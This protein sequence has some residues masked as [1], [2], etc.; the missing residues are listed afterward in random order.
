VR[1]DR[2]VA[3]KGQA[4]ERDGLSVA[5]DRR[6]ECASE[7]WVAPVRPK[8]KLQLRKIVARPRQIT[9][10]VTPTAEMPQAPSRF[11]LMRSVRFPRATRRRVVTGKWRGSARGA[12]SFD[13]SHPVEERTIAAERAWP[14][15]VVVCKR[16]QFLASCTVP[17]GKSERCA[18]SRRC[19][20]KVT[21]GRYFFQTRRRSKSPATVRFEGIRT[22]QL[23]F[24]RDSNSLRSTTAG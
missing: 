24:A 13:D 11:A 23:L 17:A 7:S 2:F 14:P 1:R 8:L 19:R 21:F 6:N 20:R 9:A 15:A 10:K 12:I 5:G 18:I 16:E 3:G 4:L 22:R